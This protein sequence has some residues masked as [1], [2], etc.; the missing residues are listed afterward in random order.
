VNKTKTGLGVTPFKK[1]IPKK[2]VLNVIKSC[3][4]TQES[5]SKVH[6]MGQGVGY[7][8][9]MQFQKGTRVL[10]FDVL[11]THSLMLPLPVEIQK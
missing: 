10:R 6:G 9:S 7:F 11:N 5:I 3:Q 8:L 2:K 1:I 4:T